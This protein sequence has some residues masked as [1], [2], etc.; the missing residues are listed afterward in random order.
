MQ[1]GKGISFL[2]N[3]ARLPETIINFRWIIDLSL[4]VR[5]IKVFV[6]CLEEYLHHLG[7]GK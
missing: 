2:T 7:V 3:E 6:R 5:I 1:I 4:K